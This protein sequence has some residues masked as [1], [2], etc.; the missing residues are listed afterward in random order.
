MTDDKNAETAAD[1]IDAL[2]AMMAADPEDQDVRLQLADLLF[3]KVEF[4]EEATPEDTERFRAVI[5]KLPPHWQHHYAAY[6]AYLALDDEKFAQELSTAIGLAAEAGE[7]LDDPDVLYWDWISPFEDGAAPALWQSL[8]D[9][10][11][12]HGPDAIAVLALRGMAAWT[13]AATI[14]EFAKVLEQ[15][16]GFWVAAAG[17]GR[18]HAGLGNWRGAY[19]AYQRALKSE[20]A[21]DVASIWFDLGYCCGKLRD[22]EGEEHAYRSCLEVEPDYPF[23]RNNLGWSLV[24]QSRFAEALPV[25]EEAIE[26][27]NDGKYPLRNMART[28]RKLGRYEEAIG[29]LEKDL[30]GGRLSKWASKQLEEVQ[31]MMA[32]QYVDSAPNAGAYEGDEDECEEIESAI[33]GFEEPGPEEEPPRSLRETMRKGQEPVPTRP[34]H[35]QVPEGVV[36]NQALKLQLEET[37]EAL[38]EGMIHRRRPVFGRSLRIY[39]HEDHG[40]GR[41]LGIPGIGRIDLLAV[42]EANDELLVIELKRGKGT[43]EVVGQLFRYLGWV[44]QHFARQGQRVRGVICVH[45]ASE[46][47]RIAVSAAENVELY[48]YGLS[49][50]R[51]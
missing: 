45:E 42:D 36:G 13:P 4:D 38:I 9:K 21:R 26:R 43:D 2:E 47:L 37:L 16:P 46:R 15:D 40:Y 24:R 48:E 35:A 19:R 34:L 30:V 12:E 3:D 22:R 44:K 14:D 8:A 10:L 39:D 5:A 17:T 1:S 23:A 6:H 20:G 50:T 18:A 25:F 28:L 32:S 7:A 27:G 41:Q 11:G 49:F 33:P 51:A 29:Y 31:S